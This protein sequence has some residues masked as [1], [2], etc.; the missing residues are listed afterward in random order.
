MY[1]IA[2]TKFFL[3]KVNFLL[4]QKFQ[5]YIIQSKQVSLKI[6]SLFFTKLNRTEYRFTHCRSLIVNITL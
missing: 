4:N 3:L 2:P 5:D 6:L 1:N